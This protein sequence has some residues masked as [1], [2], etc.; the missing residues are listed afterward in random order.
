[1]LITRSSGNSFFN[2]NPLTYS[3][4]TK[5]KEDVFTIYLHQAFIGYAVNFLKEVGI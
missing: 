1:M 5:V 4:T 2:F 3:N